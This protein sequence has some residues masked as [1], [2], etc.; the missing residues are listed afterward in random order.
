MNLKDKRLEE[1]KEFIELYKNKKHSK[2]YLIKI[3]HRAQMLFGYLDNDVIKEI[4]K[5]INI[6]VSKIWGVATF[7]HFFKFEATGKHTISVCMGTACYVK[8][9]ELVL[10]AIKKELNINKVGE[11][12][13][14]KLFTL[15]DTRCIGTCGLAPVMT[16]DGEVYGKL[17]P[18]KVVEILKSYRS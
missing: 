5:K 12:T 13:E 1:L 2:S 17:T 14:D 11:T 16:I 6:S 15:Q 3:L 8:G 4:S 18:K 9:A 10:E 7:Y